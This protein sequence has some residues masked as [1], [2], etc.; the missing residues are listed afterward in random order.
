M[1]RA[2]EIQ[3]ALLH[4]VGWEQHYDTSEF[5]IDESLTQSESGMY[6]QQIHPLLTLENLQSIAPQFKNDGEDHFSKW[7]ESKTK[8]SIMKAVNRYINDKLAKR[9]TQDLVEHKTLFDGTGRLTDLVKNRNNLVGFEIVPIRSKGITTKINKIG[10]QFTKA[11]KY[12]LYI[13]HS[14]NQGVVYTINV[15]KS[16]GNSLE[17]FDLSDIVLPYESKNN[18]AGGS[19]FI[20]YKQSELPEGSQAIYKTRDWSKGPCRTCSRTE[21]TSWQAWSKYI[22]V[23]PFRISEELLEDAGA[24]FSNDFSSDF[25]NNPC[26]MWDYEQNTYTYDTNYGIN[27]DISISCD[28]TDFIINQRYIFQD[29]IAKQLAVDM[30]RE[31]AYN[32]SVRTNRRSINASRVDIL[33]ELDGDSASMKKSGLGYQLELAYKAVELSTEG[34]DR[35]C[36]PCVNN[37]IRYRTI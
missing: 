31:F 6:F 37:G 27:L 23:H 25:K 17:W 36:L 16:A 26:I 9:T 3:E 32:A 28:L 7:L 34:I 20:C 13:Y 18:D 10:L 14:S 30:L 19:W 5:S 12:T 35:V 11:G 8:A 4:L 24:P 29:V 1:I 15:T 21:F 33:Y 2:K 22:E